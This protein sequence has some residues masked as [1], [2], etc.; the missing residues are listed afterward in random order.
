MSKRYWLKILGF[1]KRQGTLVL[2]AEQQLA[3]LQG[4]LD[5]QLG[6]VPT[7]AGFGL[8]G[9]DVV[10]L[11]S[12]DGLIAH[13]KEAV[14][15]ATGNEELALVVLA[16]LAHHVLTKGRRVAAKVNGHIEHSA[17]DD[18]D[19]LGLREFAT[20]VVQASEYAERRLRLVVLHELYTR[21]VLVEFLLLPSFEEIASG[22]V[23]HARLDDENA[24]YGGLYIIHSKQ[25]F[26]KVQRKVERRKAKD[27]NFRI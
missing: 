6:V 26:A 12:K 16:E 9:I 22:I 17:L 19:Q 27:E 21:N 5:T 14:G 11:I 15:K 7:D 18:S 3:G 20:L 2:V 4:P 25:I 1:T 8:W 23:E 10:N 13:D 24:F